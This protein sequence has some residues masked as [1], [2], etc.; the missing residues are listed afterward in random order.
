MRKPLKNFRLLCASAMVLL[1]S[2][3]SLLATSNGDPTG[4]EEETATL[5]LYRPGSWFGCAVRIKVQIDDLDPIKVRNRTRQT[6]TVPAGKDMHLKVKFR[7]KANL[8]MDLEPG[9]TYYLRGSILPG[10]LA[11]RPQLIEVTGRQGEK[12][13]NQYKFRK[14]RR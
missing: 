9:S 11:G 13:L 8:R 4:K 12:D 6:L 14:R 7:P 2:S 1:L 5:I 10:W 3:T